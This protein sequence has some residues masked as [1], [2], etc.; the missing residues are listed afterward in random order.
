MTDGQDH[1]LS[2][3]DALTKKI[4]GAQKIKFRIRGWLL[5]HVG[6]RLTQLSR[7]SKVVNCKQLLQKLGIKNVEVSCEQNLQGGKSNNSFEH[8]F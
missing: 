7:A 2:Q 3:A 8:D 6:E 5:D 1:V 4:A